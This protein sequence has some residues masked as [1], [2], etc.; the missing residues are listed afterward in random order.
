MRIYNFSLGS[1]FSL[2]LVT[3]VFLLVSNVSHGDITI[4]MRQSVATFDVLAGV[5]PA[6]DRELEAPPIFNDL[7]GQFELQNEYTA[8]AVFDNGDIAG[9]ASSYGNIFHNNM[10]AQSPNGL[11]VD[12][13]NVG[14]GMIETAG[15]GGAAS[16]TRASLNFRF[17]ISKDTP[18]TFFLD[19]DPIIGPS[20]IDIKFSSTSMPLVLVDTQEAGFVEDSGVLPAGSYRINIFTRGF[21]TSANGEPTDD[22]PYSYGL[23]FSLRVGGITCGDLNLDGDVNLLDVEGFIARLVSGDFQYEGDFNGDSVVNLL[24]VEDFI[25]ALT[26]G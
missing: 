10:I 18:Y 4:T 25:A 15:D 21:A 12:F 9:E 19:I 5:G 16:K 20:D 7:T 13:L 26:G 23:N 8:F 11:A 6:L 2:P 17:D 3:L 14:E 22:P 24:D 1:L